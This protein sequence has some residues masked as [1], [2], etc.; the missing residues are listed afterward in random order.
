M[1]R[2]R[3]DCDDDYYVGRRFIKDENRSEVCLL[4]NE[5]V[6]T[7]IAISTNLLSLP[8]PLSSTASDGGA[9]AAASW[10]L[11]IAAHAIYEV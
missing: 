10:C 11:G 7:G 3:K 6:R 9:A 4:T 1:G 2:R 5:W 8:L